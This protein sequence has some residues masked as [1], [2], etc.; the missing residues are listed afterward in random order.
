MPHGLDLQQLNVP[1]AVFLNLLDLTRVSRI[2][3]RI[4]RVSMTVERGY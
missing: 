1:G 3:D 4:S 2:S